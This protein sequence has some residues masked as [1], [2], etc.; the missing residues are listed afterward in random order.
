[1]VGGGEADDPRGPVETAG[2]GSW[3]SCGPAGTATS[4]VAKVVGGLT[5]LLKYR[6]IEYGFRP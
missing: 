4:E 6:A 3:S 5:R 2:S 1:M